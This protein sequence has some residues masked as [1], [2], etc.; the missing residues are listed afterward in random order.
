MQ[1][2]AMKDVLEE[3]TPEEQ[4]ELAEL[5]AKQPA[6]PERSSKG[7]LVVGGSDASPRV[8][9]LAAMLAMGAA[10]GNLPLDMVPDLGF[11]HAGP[12]RAKKRAFGP[13]AGTNRQRRMKQGKNW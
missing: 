11:T 4:Q 7:V 3:L 6:Q 10:I 13:G 2:K 5:L 1:E 9:A 8:G 12:S